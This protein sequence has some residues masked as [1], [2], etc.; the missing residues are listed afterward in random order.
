MRIDARPPRGAGLGDDLGLRSRSSRWW[1]FAGQAALGLAGLSV[2]SAT[3]GD[4]EVVLDG[5]RDEM[6][7][8]VENDTLGQVLDALRDKGNLRYRSTV[9]LNNV[10]KYTPAG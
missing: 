6:R 1:G 8:S 10:P 4:A 7:V 5:G 9:P 3:Q 2:V